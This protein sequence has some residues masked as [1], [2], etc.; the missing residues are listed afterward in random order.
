MTPRRI[1]VYCGSRTGSNPAYGDA[2]VSFGR[3][4]ANAGWGLVYG[5]GGTGLMGALADAARDAGAPVTGV[6][7]RAFDSREIAHTGLDDL[8]VV[9]DMHQR[10]RLM[11][12]LA[13]AFVAL[14]GGIGTLEEFFE[15][16]T[17]ATLGF[18]TARKPVGVLNTDGYFDTLLEFIDRTVRDG[19]LKQEFRTQLIIER[20]AGALVTRIEEALAGR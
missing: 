3:A 6:I 14:P 18:H 5:G 11:A 15:A 20:D 13:D 19:F 1:C 8:R 17:W 2:A 9:D 10:K 7:P 16:W 12:D 4:I